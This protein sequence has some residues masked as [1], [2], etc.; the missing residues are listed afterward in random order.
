MTR[1]LTSDTLRR[2]R[3]VSAWSAGRAEPPAVAQGA[4]VLEILPHERRCFDPRAARPSSAPQPSVALRPSTASPP[5]TAERP[6]IV[7][8]SSFGV[9]VPAA[10]NAADAATDALA[11]AG[12]ISNVRN[13]VAQS[14]TAGD[15]VPACAGACPPW[16]GKCRQPLPHTFG[17][18][19][20]KITRP[21]SAGASAGRSAARGSSAGRGAG[22]SMGEA[23]GAGS[24][25]AARADE[26][27]VA[28]GGA[29]S[30]EP[31]HVIP[32]G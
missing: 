26:E 14:R 23:G 16:S 10:A 18:G 9:D 31:I 6:W 25:V 15:H 20:C 30:G 22:S 5:A 32:H 24:G 21:S 29:R 7:R 28:A 17:R 2:Q 4:S 11:L 27:G 12:S 13:V 3:Y 1:S 8:A 19:R